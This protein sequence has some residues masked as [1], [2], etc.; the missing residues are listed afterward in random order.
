MRKKGLSKALLSL[1]S[2]LSLMPAQVWADFIIK[3]TDS[4]QVT[5]H[6]YVEEG[7]TI[8]IYTPQGVIS[9]RKD[10]VER[11]TPVDANLN[12]MT[13]LEAVSATPAPSAQSSTLVPSDKQGTTDTGKA[14][15]TEGGD[16]IG[17]SDATATELKRI[18]G[19]YQNITQQFDE[20]WKKHAEDVDSGVADEVLTE[21]RRQLEELSRAR[22]KLVEDARQVAPDNLPDWAQ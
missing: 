6:R 19:Q 8:K 22:H 4:G 2:L 3:F 14:T 16:T 10:D 21:N 12:A 9:F 1:G 5:V 7:Q 13:P 17:A 15:K 11:I 18:D 20:L